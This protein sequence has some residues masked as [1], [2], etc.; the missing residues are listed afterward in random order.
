VGSAAPDLDG[1]RGPTRHLDRHRQPIGAAI[2]SMNGARFVNDQL[3]CAGWQVEIADGQKVKG[4]APLA[5]NLVLTLAAGIT[6]G[7][8]VGRFTNR[9]RL[10]GTR[11][12]HQPVHARAFAGTTDAA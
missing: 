2:E 3:E 5:C 10:A 9:Q 1:L 7:L 12:V 8:P 11:R 6:L 4:L